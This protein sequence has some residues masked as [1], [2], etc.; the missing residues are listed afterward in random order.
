MRRG[1]LG[2]ISGGILGLG[3]LKLGSRNPTV[4]RHPAFSRTIEACLR[5]VEGSRNEGWKAMPY[6]LLNEFK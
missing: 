3:T 1:I 4:C 6:K 5:A 2:V